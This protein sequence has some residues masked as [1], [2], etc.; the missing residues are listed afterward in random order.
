M[1]RVTT[2]GGRL[3]S[4]SWCHG[5]LVL[6]SSLLCGVLGSTFML[7]NPYH[8]ELVALSDGIWMLTN[9]SEY[10][11]GFISSLS[12]SQISFSLFAH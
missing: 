4:L 7:P 2:T 6:V 8:V 1:F 11:E 9:Y 10:T 12:S 3:P 5:V